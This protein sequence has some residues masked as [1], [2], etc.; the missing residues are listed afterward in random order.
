MWPQQPV[1]IVDALLCLLT[2][3]ACSLTVPDSMYVRVCNVML[4]LA[5]T[6]HAIASNG[7]GMAEPTKQPSTITQMGPS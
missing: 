5:A 1:N 2:H 4:T 7:D 6:C 3:C